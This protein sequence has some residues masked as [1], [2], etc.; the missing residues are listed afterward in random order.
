MGDDREHQPPD[1]Q[2]E[3]IEGGARP[4]G[5][6]WWWASAAVLVAVAVAAAYVLGLGRSTGESDAAGPQPSPATGAVPEGV[7]TGDADSAFGAPTE[8]SVTVT[9][10]SAPILG[11][12]DGWELFT[13]SRVEG[14][15]SRAQLATGRITHTQLPAL[16][17][18]G[19][20]SFLVGPDRALVHPIDLVPGYVVPDGAPAQLQ[21]I[22]DGGLVL[23]GPRPGQ[24]WVE[25]GD[26]PRLRLALFDL[27]GRDLGRSFT[28]P[29]SN[30][31]PVVADGRGYVFAN[32]TGGV[33]DVRPDGARRVTTGA[34]LAVGPTALL[35]VSC[36]VEAR[37]HWVVLDR[38]TGKRRVVGKASAEFVGEAGSISPDGSI[39]AVV[40]ANTGRASLH[41]LDLRTGTERVLSLRGTPSPGRSG[42][43][44]SPDSRLLFVADGGVQVIDL[45]GGI[46]DRAPQ[47]QDLGI[48]LRGATEIAVRPAG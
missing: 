28:L 35:L 12:T 18:S 30:P 46:T 32:G 10:V 7:S 33:Y 26:G 23:P 38:D 13:Y 25:S 45:Q 8:D 6:R 37:C 4:I 5:R 42:L 2:P 21:Q 31:W 11:V 36:D 3:V 29:F 34:L 1:Q 41:L 22:S 27:R 15:L 20:I 48:G 24:V 19:P 16:D 9:Q 17:S 14:V 40:H 47:A 44:W 39:A 43:A